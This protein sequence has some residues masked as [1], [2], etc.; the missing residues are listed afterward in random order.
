[1]VNMNAFAIILFI[2]INII[3]LRRYNY[4]IRNHNRSLVICAILIGSWLYCPINPIQLQSIVIAQGSFERVSLSPIWGIVS[5]ST[6]TTF[7]IRE[8][9][10]LECQLF[11]WLLLFYQFQEAP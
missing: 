2:G 7:V 8:F 3:L 5:H 9:Y 10:G 11:F 4:T 1:M 6:N